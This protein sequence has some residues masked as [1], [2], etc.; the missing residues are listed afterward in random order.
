[1]ELNAFRELL[2][3]NDA[4]SA[5]LPPDL[6]GSC[7]ANCSLQNP[8]NAFCNTLYACETSIPQLHFLLESRTKSNKDFPFVQPNTCQTLQISKGSREEEEN[9]K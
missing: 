3:H 5:I 8:R 6:S 9:K 2:V 7:K 1:M 4:I